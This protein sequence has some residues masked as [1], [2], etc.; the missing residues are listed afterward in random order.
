MTRKHQ[1]SGDDP[2]D[3]IEGVRPISD[4]VARIARQLGLGDSLGLSSVFERWEDVVGPVLG[5]HTRP[6]RLRDGELVVVVDEASW[7]TEV[8]FMADTIAARCNEQAGRP[9]VDRVVVRVDAFPSDRVGGAA[10]D[11][12]PK[13]AWNIG[14]KPRANRPD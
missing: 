6:D 1:Q 14:Q 11:G 12:A 4:S 8:R 9:M 2:V 5:A 3:G 13:K 10:T 7:A